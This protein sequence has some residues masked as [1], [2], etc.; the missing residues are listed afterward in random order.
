MEHPRKASGYSGWNA[1]FQLTTIKKRT[2]VWKITTKITLFQYLLSHI[3]LPISFWCISFSYIN[4]YCS[5]PSW[6]FMNHISF[7]KVFWGISFCCIISYICRFHF[8]SLYLLF[9]CVFF[10]S[11]SCS[12]SFFICF[13]R[14]IFPQCLVYM[15]WLFWRIQILSQNIFTP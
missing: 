12:C 15:F 9:S 1:V 6:C 2:A 4:F 10:L 8:S 3:F 11:F 14:L 5:K 13:S 7:A